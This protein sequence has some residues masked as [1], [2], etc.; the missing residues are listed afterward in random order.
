MDTSPPSADHDLLDRALAGDEA[1]FVTLVGLY[2]A[3]LLRFARTFVRQPSQAE[4]VVQETWLAVLTGLERFERRASFKTW[5]FRILS[6]RARTK[7]VR[8]SRFDQLD[9]AADG[10]GVS[11][12]RFTAEGRWRTPPREWRLTPERLLQS[13]EARAIVEAALETLPAGQRAVVTLRDV[14]GLEA[15]EVCNVLGITETNQRVLLHRGRARIREALAE[16]LD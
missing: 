10:G 1:A 3:P 11:D 12:D 15:A 16:G 5:L 4:D 8:E 7:A 6:N 14:E 13:K 2:H 9:P